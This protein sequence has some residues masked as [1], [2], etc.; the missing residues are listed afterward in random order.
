MQVEGAHEW[1]VVSDQNRSWGRRRSLNELSV[2]GID[3]RDI[4]QSLDL[5]DLI[6][7]HKK[8]IFVGIAEK[9]CNDDHDFR[10]VWCA[11]KLPV[12]L[13]AI[14]GEKRPKHDERMAMALDR[15][16][17]IGERRVRSAVGVGPPLRADHRVLIEHKPSLH[18]NELAESRGDQFADL[19]D[20]DLHELS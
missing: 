19:L 5:H 16:Q 12:Y 3:V 8:V 18:P 11:A 15:E 9:C 13:T 1:D 10:I 14:D 6:V 4:V 20:I 17:E 2:A 7:L